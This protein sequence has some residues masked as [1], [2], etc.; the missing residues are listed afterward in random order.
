[1]KI[2]GQ[3]WYDGEMV[4]VYECEQCNFVSKFVDSVEKHEQ[5]HKK[6]FHEDEFKAGVL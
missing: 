2:A 6:E 5:T 3:T 1:M 4:I